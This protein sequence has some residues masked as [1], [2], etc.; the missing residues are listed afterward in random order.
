MEPFKR[1]ILINKNMGMKVRVVISI[2]ALAIWFL[3]TSGS[4]PEINQNPQ[5][6]LKDYYA[7]YFPIG[8]AVSPRTLKTD[9]AQLIR[10]QFNSVTAENAMKIGPIHPEENKFNWTSAD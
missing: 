6:G 2:A 5:K 10:A 3:S 1:L 4:K 9:E 8:V 7:S